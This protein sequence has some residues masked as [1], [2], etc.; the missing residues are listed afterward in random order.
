MGKNRLTFSIQDE[1]D[2]LKT[3]AASRFIAKNEN[4][5]KLPL[6]PR[7]NSRNHMAKEL[8]QFRE[9]GDKPNNWSSLPPL[10]SSSKEDEE[11]L[12]RTIKARKQLPSI[13]Q[14]QLRYKTILL[15][16][17]LHVFIIAH[18]LIVLFHNN[19]CLEPCFKKGGSYSHSQGAEHQEETR[20]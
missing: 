4:N 2:Q 5:K 19:L 8:N 1:A 16:I 11:A 12:L 17:S 18:F 13:I 20:K 7:V 10:P 15:N 9:Q 6:R 3:D 14:K